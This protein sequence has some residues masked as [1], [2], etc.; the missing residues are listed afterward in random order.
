MVLLHGNHHHLWL[1]LALYIRHLL[2]LRVAL[3]WVAL[4]RIALLWIALMLH[5]SFTEDNFTNCISL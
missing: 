4:L 5:L 2:L 3:L 1:G